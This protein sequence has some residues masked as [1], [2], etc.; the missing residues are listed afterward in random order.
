[1]VY[2]ILPVDRDTNK[3]VH[4]PHPNMVQCK[5]LNPLCTYVTPPCEKQKDPAR[6]DGVFCHF[7]A[8]SVS[9]YIED[10][11]NLRYIIFTRYIPRRLHRLD[12]TAIVALPV[13]LE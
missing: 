10:I 6:P 8:K 7:G 9:K 1:M 4:R 5:V 13:S 3:V 12:V 2:G 11:D